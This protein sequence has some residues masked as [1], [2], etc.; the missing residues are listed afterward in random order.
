M[1]ELYELIQCVWCII[2]GKCPNCGFKGLFLKIKECLYCGRTCCERCARYVVTIG[3]ADK[4][5]C[6]EECARKFEEK[7]LTYPLKDIGT[8]LD[9]EFY[10]VEDKLWHSACIDALNKNDP[11]RENWFNLLKQGLAM[12]IMHVE[13]KSSDGKHESDLGRKFR[14]RALLTLAHNMETVGRPLDAAKIYEE[15]LK[16]YAKA[17]E[18]REKEKQV[19]VKKM[20]ISVNLNELI[21][22]V[23]NG[24]IVVVY[25]C[26]HCG[27]KLK[28][29]R[30][31]SV[32]SMK[33]CE[34]CGSEIETMKLTE[35][36]RTALS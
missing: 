25:R 29:S 36:L 8:F 24:G 33:V 18:L 23:K 34:H 27:G 6:S 32:E 11:S 10:D 31:T 26:P 15:H 17:R 19:L 5:A 12:R 9:S 30:N 20:D 16:M 35:L 4:W 1:K 21:Q 2:M 7:V 3:S 14:R 28:I 13:T 22:Q